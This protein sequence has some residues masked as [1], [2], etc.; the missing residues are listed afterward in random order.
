MQPVLLEVLTGDGAGTYPSLILDVRE[1]EAIVVG[2]PLDRG[3]EIAL[4][5]GADL[6]LLVARPD[7]L[8]YLRTRVHSLTGEEPSLQLHWPHRT[9]KVQRRNH[10][11]VSVMLPGRV[12]IRPALTVP[13]R[14]PPERLLPAK[15]VD[16]SAGGARFNLPEPLAVGTQ[17]RVAVEL[18][19]SGEQ[20]SEARVLRGGEHERAV[21]EQ[22]Y[23]AA[24]E[25]VGMLESVRR[26]I[27]RFV[28][29]VQ[30][31]HIR[32]GAE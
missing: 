24:V 16:L 7:G 6:N 20:G 14:R 9:D 8:Y 31:E 19:E 22:R 29:D 3:R 28:F 32:K 2:V 17:V 4:K 18:P 30:R 12:W 21:A 1:G 13:G 10:V 5:P 26:E 27:T 23:W 25:F 11:R 15:L